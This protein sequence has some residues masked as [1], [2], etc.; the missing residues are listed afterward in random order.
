M[1]FRVAQVTHL[2]E[3]DLE[4]VGFTGIEI[5]ETGGKRYWQ[6]NRLPHL[7]SIILPIDWGFTLVVSQRDIPEPTRDHD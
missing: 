7:S 4:V 1:I 3:L 6:I 5:R 2:P